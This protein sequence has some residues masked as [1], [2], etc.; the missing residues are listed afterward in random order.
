MMAGHYTTALLANLK[1]PRKTL[2]YFLIVSQLQDLL[3]FVFH[4]LGLE[5]TEP[6]DVF[7]ATLGEMTVNMMYVT[8]SS[9]R[10]F[11]SLLSLSLVKSHSGARR[12]D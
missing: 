11:G 8:T 3:W 7:D 1:Y 9:P 6:A 2:L 5:V 12:L 10:R 4:Y